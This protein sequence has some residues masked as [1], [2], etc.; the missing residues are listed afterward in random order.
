MHTGEGR[1]RT[2]PKCGGTNVH[3]SRARTPGER[4]IRRFLPIRYWRCHDCDHRESRWDWTRGRKMI[5]NLAF[6]ALV[7]LTFILY[8]KLS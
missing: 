3:R 7:A 5:A 2:C 8:K 4:R 6:W 1:P